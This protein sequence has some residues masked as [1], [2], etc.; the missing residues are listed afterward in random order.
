MFFDQSPYHKLLK[1]KVPK[2]N[3]FMS[4]HG[5]ALHSSLRGAVYYRFPFPAV[6]GSKASVYQKRREYDS[7]LQFAKGKQTICRIESL[8]GGS[9]ISASGNMDYPPIAAEPFEYFMGV[10]SLP[11]IIRY[12]KVPTSIL[13]R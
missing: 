8:T 12:S 2:E 4:V 9:V 5:D 3:I 11:A 10:K 7:R 13:V 6:S 1:Q